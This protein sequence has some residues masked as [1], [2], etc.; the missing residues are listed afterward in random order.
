MNGAALFRALVLSLGWLMLGLAAFAAVWGDFIL[1]ARQRPV[2]AVVVSTRVDW[3][4]RGKQGGKY[5]LP[6]VSLRYEFNSRHYTV[7]DDLGE[8]PM[9]GYDIAR[10]RIAPF[11]VGRE[12]TVLVDPSSG[13]SGRMPRRVQWDRYGVFA[14]LAALLTAALVWHVRLGP[15]QPDPKSRPL[16]VL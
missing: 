5:F 3:T 2:R 12:V 16:P 13:A 8:L 9:S 6:I 10:A 4:N 15:G 11:P 1:T 7:N 14:V